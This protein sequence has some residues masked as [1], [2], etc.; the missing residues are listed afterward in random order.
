MKASLMMMEIKSR[1]SRGGRSRIWCSRTEVMARRRGAGME[2][3]RDIE[4]LDYRF[5]G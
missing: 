1:E 2:E 4:G 5:Y 3:D